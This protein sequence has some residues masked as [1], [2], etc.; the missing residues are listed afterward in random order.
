MEKWQ[1]FQ[2]MILGMFLYMEETETRNPPL[3]LHKNQ[4]QMN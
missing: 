4:L 2:Q 1:P 3:T